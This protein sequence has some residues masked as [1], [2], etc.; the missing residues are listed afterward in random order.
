[1][2]RIKLLTVLSKKPIVY[3]TK[4]YDFNS[5]EDGALP[6]A[7]TGSTYAISSGKV[8]NTPN[9]GTELFTDGSLEATYTDGLC[10]SLNKGG[11]PTVEES[12]DAHL[13]DKAQ[14]FNG[15]LNQ[16]INQYQASTNGKWLYLSGWFKRASGAND[17]TN[18]R[19]TANA[20]PGEFQ[21]QRTIKDAAY[22][23]KILV[24]KSYASAT[25]INLA[26]ESVAS[27]AG[28][29]VIVD[30]FSLKEIPLSEMYATTPYDT[31]NASVRAHIDLE[32]GNGIAG[33]VARLD[34]A[35]NPQNY[36]IAS[37]NTQSTS[38]GVEFG[39]VSLVKV[40]G[41]TLTV[42]INNVS[43]GRLAANGDYVEIDCS[44]N[45]VSLFYN[46]VQIGATQTVSDA[47]IVNNKLFGF[48]AVGGG[49]VNSFKVG[50]TLSK[51]YSGVT[52]VVNSTQIIDQVT[53]K[54]SG[55]PAMEFNS[56]GE[57]VL[58]YRRASNHGAT[59]SLLHI[60]FSDDYGS[61]WS[62]EDKDLSDAAI[63]G[64]PYRPTNIA[65]LETDHPQEPWLYAAPNGNLILHTWQQ[66]AGTWQSVST[67][68]GKTWSD[69][70]A[71]PITG[72]S[73]AGVFATD[74]H[75]VYDGVIY[76]A[77]RDFGS[78]P[79]YQM[80]FMKS[81]DNGANWVY[82]AN[83]NPV[84]EDIPTVEVGIEY[85]G[86]SRIIAIFR[87][88]YDMATIRS[89]SDDMGATWSQ[90]EAI[91]YNIPKSGRH[92]IM[93]K[94]HLEGAANWWEDTNL[95][96]CGFVFAPPGRKAAMWYSTD[97]G[98]TWSPPRYVESEALLYE[99]T[100]YADFIYNGTTGE[101]VL[102]TYVGEYEHSAAVLKQYN[103]MPTW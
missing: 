48:Y 88:I 45:S 32:H 33:L 87:D 67:D 28:D 43:V 40:V 16:N 20:F 34:S 42:L 9:L 11:T 25:T 78:A 10:T 38:N 37:V 101:Y 6:E 62:A 72:H 80:I 58:I 83:M 85:L 96:M 82:V 60:R 63:T 81:I 102:I 65:Y 77:A 59:D 35:A 99:D 39:Y 92:R 5:S 64:F 70:E 49:N 56:D 23:Q 75:F 26:I 73:G 74:D 57:L 93:T 52:H 29:T 50:Q 71:L 69:G 54:W 46:G 97:A 17:K 51:T 12:A 24:F 53:L 7:F 18:F 1:M 44:G 19:R 31:A 36:L 90:L 55:R 3:P 22:T 15:T 76:A 21:A 68:G 84:D 94:K 89:Y 61:T 4:E 91:T 86:N 8:F 27:G 14:Q 2:D 100:G 95:V 13:G 79:P 98:Q 41:G 30:D 103:I 66:S 47:G